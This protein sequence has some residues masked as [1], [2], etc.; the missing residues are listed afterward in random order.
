[1]AI[2]INDYVVRLQVPEN[3]VLLVKGLNA[4]QDLFDILSCFTLFK[5]ALNLEVLTQITAWAVI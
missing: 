1:M 4:K 3:D 2:S 5:V